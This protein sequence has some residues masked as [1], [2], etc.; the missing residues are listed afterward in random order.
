MKIASGELVLIP[1]DQINKPRRAVTL[2]CSEL[3]EAFQLGAPEGATHYD[4]Y[5][6]YWMIK[7]DKAWFSFKG[8]EK[9]NRYAFTDIQ[10]YINDGTVK[11]L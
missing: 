3:L 10:E 5:D 9:W 6:D 2:T 4:I 7:G 1:K 11:P 8:C